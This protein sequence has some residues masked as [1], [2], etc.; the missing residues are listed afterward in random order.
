MI[1]L[2]HLFY[3]RGEDLAATLFHF[4]SRIPLSLIVYFPKGGKKTLLIWFLIIKSFTFKDYF[5]LDEFQTF[6]H[7]S[8]TEIETE[9]ATDCFSSS[10]SFSDSETGKFPRKPQLNSWKYYVRIIIR[11]SPNRKSYHLLGA[12]FFLSKTILTPSKPVFINYSSFE[13]I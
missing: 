13:K 3:L 11:R 1:N 5:F 6:L 4:L 10:G 8:K 12:F 7:L 9:S 2:I